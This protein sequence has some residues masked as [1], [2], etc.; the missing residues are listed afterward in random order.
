MGIREAIDPLIEYANVVTFKPPSPSQRERANR[1]VSG[2]GWY[3]DAAIRGS[4]S[5]CQKPRWQR[6]AQKKSRF[7][8]R[9]FKQPGAKLTP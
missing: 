5:A 7:A 6:V 4:L 9:P 3:A 8:F 1:A 2:K